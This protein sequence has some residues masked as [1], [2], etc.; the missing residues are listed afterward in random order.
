MSKVTAALR[1]GIT[2]IWLVVLFLTGTG[3][4]IPSH[5]HVE[6]L[7]YAGLHRMVRLPTSVQCFH[8]SLRSHYV[9]LPQAVLLA[10]FLLLLG[11]HFIQTGSQWN[12]LSQMSPS[13]SIP[14]PDALMRCC[15][16][17]SSLQPVA[18]RA[19]VLSS[20]LPHAGDWFTVVPSA[21]LGLHLSDREFCLCLQY[22]LGTQIYK[23]EGICPVCHHLADPMGNHQ[24]GCGGKNV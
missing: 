8:W 12:P 17:G 18:I 2:P 19:F 6:A 5:A 1:P 23:E 15:I 9:I 24:V 10:Q 13:T 4:R 11:L 16:A 20:S 3:L 22:C 7:I 14:S 21:M